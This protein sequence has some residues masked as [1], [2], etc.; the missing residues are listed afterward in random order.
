MHA[1]SSMEFLE[2]PMN[3][4]FTSIEAAYILFGWEI[5]MKIINLEAPHDHWH[6]P[7]I[8]PVFMESYENFIS[9]AV[10]SYDIVRLYSTDSRPIVTDLFDYSRYTVRFQYVYGRVFHKCQTNEKTD[11]HYYA[12]HSDEAGLRERF[13]DIAY[14][15]DP[16]KV[17]FII[18]Q[19]AIIICVIFQTTITLDS[20][21]ILPIIFPSH[22]AGLTG[23]TIHS[24]KNPNY[25]I[26]ILL[27]LNGCMQRGQLHIRFHGQEGG[28]A[29]KQHTNVRS[30]V[31][32]FVK[33][34][35]CGNLRPTLNLTSAA[36]TDL[37]IK[38][39]DEAISSG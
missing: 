23:E 18:Q 20:S 38:M 19:L 7:N 22:G 5:R 21:V 27:T 29:R 25:S 32:H 10:K 4:I 9:T 35:F 16:R 37:L 3:V 12:A 31:C 15:Y 2:S 39:L 13:I 28:T 36:A 1:T 8:R 33:Y 17:Q 26:D 14:E 34:T 24:T 11:E 30:F 6:I